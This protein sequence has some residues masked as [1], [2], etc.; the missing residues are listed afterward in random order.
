[1]DRTFPRAD[2]R[3]DKGLQGEGPKPR[4]FAHAGPLTEANHWATLPI[5]LRRKL[6]GCQEHEDSQRPGSGEVSPRRT[7]ARVEVGLIRQER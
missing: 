3:M 2:G 4:N 6:V 7:Y 1:M 5:G